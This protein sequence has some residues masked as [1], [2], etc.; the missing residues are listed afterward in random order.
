MRLG[1]VAEVVWASKDKEEITRFDGNEGVL[2]SLYKAGDANTV[3][4]AN[5]VKEKLLQLQ[6]SLPRG[7]ELKIQFD[8]S[9]FIEQSISEVKQSLL[10]G[11]FLAVCV[12]LAFLRDF[13]LT[14]IITT[15]IPLSLVAAFIFMYRF[16]VSLNIMSLGGLT[17]GVGMLVDSAIVVL[18]SIHRQREKG[19]TISQAA[20][21]GTRQTVQPPQP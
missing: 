18:E 4:V 20:I 7:V 12:L 8:Q 11:G 17:L 1:D 2:I 14:A 13:R 6:R 15:A 21:K 9:R 5:T 19:L 3:N 10:L 16:E